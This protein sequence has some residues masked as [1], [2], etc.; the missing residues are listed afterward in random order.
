MACNQSEHEATANKVWSEIKSQSLKFS[1]RR[2]LYYFISRRVL[3][4]VT[5]TAPLLFMPAIEDCI[6]L[7]LGQKYPVEPTACACCLPYPFQN[8]DTSELHQSHLQTKIPYRSC[9]VLTGRML[10]QWENMPS[11]QCTLHYCPCQENRSLPP[12]H[13]MSEINGQSAIFNLRS[14]WH[15]FLTAARVLSVSS[16]DELMLRYIRAS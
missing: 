16:T 2:P 12:S 1:V 15:L 6:P 14:L 3:K 11:G 13:S 4:T 5:C 8:L 7:I 9:L 10:L